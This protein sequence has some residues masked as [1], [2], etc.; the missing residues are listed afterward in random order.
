M[1]SKNVTESILSVAEASSVKTC[2]YESYFCIAISS[3]LEQLVTYSFDVWNMSSSFF[4]NQ[5]SNFSLRPFCFYDVCQNVSNCF[6]FP[7][8]I[9]LILNS[10]TRLNSLHTDVTWCSP[11]GRNN[12]Y[13]L[14]IENIRNLQD[15]RF[16]TYGRLFSFFHLKLFEY[17]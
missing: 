17:G 13:T 6:Y 3:D 5:Q 4:S 16:D 14:Q 1:E 9:F 10:T 7:P 15:F 11:P 2:T 12:V 8:S